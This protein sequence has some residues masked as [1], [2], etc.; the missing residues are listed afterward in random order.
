[1]KKHHVSRFPWGN[2]RRLGEEVSMDTIF[3]T[4]TGYDD[5]TCAQVFVALL[6]RMINMYPMPSKASGNVLKAYK[7][8]M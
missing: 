3:L 6:S 8:F 5:S 4:K 2:R 7:D 1:M